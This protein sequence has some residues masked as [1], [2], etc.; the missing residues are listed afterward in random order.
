MEGVGEELSDILKV[1]LRGAADA[2]DLGPSIDHKSGYKLYSPFQ[3][4]NL[5]IGN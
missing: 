1:V 4:G 3:K 5:L 2:L